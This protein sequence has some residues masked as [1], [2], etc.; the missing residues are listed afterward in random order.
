MLEGRGTFFYMWVSSA[1]VSSLAELLCLLGRVPLQ[2]LSLHHL[3]GSILMDGAAAAQWVL[4]GQAT[5]TKAFL[6]M[7]GCPCHLLQK[8]KLL[9]E[10]PQPGLL[11]PGRG[12]GVL[13]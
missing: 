4:A 12:R 2:G 1:L 7:P 5:T 8:C 9:C 13:T 6:C 11:P 3:A 10:D